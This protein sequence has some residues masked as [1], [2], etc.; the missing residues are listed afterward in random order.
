[1]ASLA[2]S[3]M[4]L[5]GALVVVAPSSASACGAALTRKDVFR[6]M[7]NGKMAE[8]SGGMETLS[9]KTLNL[10]YKSDKKIY[11][12]GS[13]AE[14]KVNVTRP[15]KEDPA[16]QGIPMDR[17]YVE[18]AE[19]ITVGVGLSIGRVFLPGAAITDAN[20]DALVRIKIESYAPAGQ[21]AD[22]SVYAWN[23]LQ[24]TPCLTVQEYGYSTAPRMFRTTR[25]S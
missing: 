12:I 7:R 23:V 17:P 1:L 14:I 9:L 5:G 20:G 18:P 4:L 22:V 19:G 24:E 8:A 15:A 21:W 11:K 16:G 6:A 2:L 3:L 13:I 10:D 25:P